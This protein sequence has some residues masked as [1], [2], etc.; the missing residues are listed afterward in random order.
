MKRVAYVVALLALT[1]GALKAQ[2]EPGRFSVTTRLGAITPERAASMDVGGL[3]GLDTEYSFNRYFALGTTVDVSRSNTHR[4][5]FVARLRYG[6]ASIG[7]GDTVY[8]QYL[9]QPVNTI[10]LGAFALARY[11]AGRI[12]PFVMGGV[13]NYTMLLDTQVAGRAARKNA[14]SYTVGGGVWFQL[15]ER[16]GIQLDV[17]SVT[18]QNYDRGF[19]DPS[20]GRSPNMVFPEDFPAVP[21]AKKTAQNTVMTL[22]FRY[23]P[24][25]TGGN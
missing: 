23:I 18:L 11:P 21:A 17:R 4:E 22:G 12:A 20:S 19:L 13:G 10:N 15:S 9:S 1:A 16:T 8:Y 24:G 25:P 14:M 2:V 5:D 6:N 7:G 3:V